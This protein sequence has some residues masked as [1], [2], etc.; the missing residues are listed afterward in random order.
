[1]ILKGD[2]LQ[3]SISHL[4]QDRNER[5]FNHRC[6]AYRAVRK[7]K[8]IGKI[9]ARN[10]WAHL[11]QCWMKR[12]PMILKGDLLQWSV[13]HL[14]KDRNERHFNQRYLTYIATRK[15]KN[16]G[17]ISAGNN[18]AHLAQC[19]LKGKS[20]IPNGDLLKWSISHLVKDRNGR[21]FN[22]RY[23]TY[24][25]TRK[26]KNIGKISARNNCAQLAQCW[27]KGK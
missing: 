24:R 7:C 4:A 23:L 11:T 10:N 8:N 26:C 17:K 3:R 13:S 19:W 25:A 2:L 6:L 14:A 15:C 12:K 16:I 22:Q 1:M 9:S 5:H 27:S 20:T 18:W 21:H